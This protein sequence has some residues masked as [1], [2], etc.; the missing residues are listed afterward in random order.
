MRE[1]IQG[2]RQRRAEK[3]RKLLHHLTDLVMAIYALLK[4]PLNVSLPELNCPHHTKEENIIHSCPFNTL[5]SACAQND[6]P[7]V[8]S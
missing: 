3:F 4:C 5:Q 7:V 1:E 2:E 8:F 6:A